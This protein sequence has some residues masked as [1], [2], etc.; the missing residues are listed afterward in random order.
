MFIRSEMAA[1]LGLLSC[2]AM[3]LLDFKSAFIKNYRFNLFEGVLGFW[4]IG[5]AHV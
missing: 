4:E 1:D 3:S 5:R 2:E